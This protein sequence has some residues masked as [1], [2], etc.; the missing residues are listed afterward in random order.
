MATKKTVKRKA[1]AKPRA[2]AKTRA[3][4]K[5]RVARTRVSAKKPVAFYS[6]PMT[7]ISNGVDKVFGFFK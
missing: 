2:R 5:A 3:K 7:V 6:Q 4:P 1:K